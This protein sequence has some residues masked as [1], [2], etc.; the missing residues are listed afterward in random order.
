M[1]DT[2]TNNN[3]SLNLFTN[4][5]SDFLNTYIL[6]VI[7]EHVNANPGVLTVESLSLALNLPN[8]NVIVN[9]S[10]NTK[11]LSESKTAIGSMQ[12]S[13]PSIKAAAKSRK[14]QSVLE[15]IKGVEC[16]HVWIKGPDADEGKSCGRRPCVEGTDYCKQHIADVNKVPRKRSRQA[17]AKQSSKFSPIA[18]YFMNV[19]ASN[20]NLPTGYEEPSNPDDGP[21]ISVV[22]YDVARFLYRDPL[23]NFILYNPDPDNI[24]PICIGKLDSITNEI[25]PLNAEE[26]EKVKSTGFPIGILPEEKVKAEEKVEVIVPTTS[27]PK[28][29]IPIIPVAI[30]AAE[31]VEVPKTT[32]VTSAPNVPIIPSVARKASP[33][34]LSKASPKGSPKPVIPKASPKV[35]HANP[36]I[37]TANIPQIPKAATSKNLPVVPVLSSNTGMPQIPMI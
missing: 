37:P 34:T 33:K 14:T 20:T 5:V 35:K 27:A 11:P 30:P 4:A 22:E 7:V 31:K 2:T 25:R 19:T 10:T 17:V 15:P 1:A 16:A 18:P 13:V 36:N 6:P 12:T 8:S 3:T 21:V 23:H 28:P 32:P 9:T 26:E 29:E 24:D